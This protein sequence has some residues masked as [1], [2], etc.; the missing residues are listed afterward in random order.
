MM[1]VLS[2]AIR[3]VG[4]V[5]AADFFTGFIHWLE[6]TFWTEETPFLGK[7][8]IQPNELHHRRPSAFLEKNWWQSSY[9]AIGVGTI[10]VLITFLLHRLNW[11]I[12]LFVLISINATQIH[13]FS[14]QAQSKIPFIIRLL[15]NLRIIQ[16]SRHHVKHH[17]GNNNSHYCLVTPILN[18]I[19]DYLCFWKG[20]EKILEPILGKSRK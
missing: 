2:I 20:M 16:N 19:L 8:L 15:Q 6:D 17:R 10:L 5:L 7:W 13:K 12:W 14:H 11:E 1:H 18:P 4:M 3:T 9:D